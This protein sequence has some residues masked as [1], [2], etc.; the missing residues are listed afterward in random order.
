MNR[1]IA[2]L[3][4]FALALAALLPGGVWQADS[5]I[6]ASS[7]GKITDVAGTA[8]IR[9]LGSVGARQARRWMN[10]FENDVI[11]TG[12]NGK[13]RVLLNDSSVITLTS[14]SKLR[15]SEQVYNP[16]R[17]E[18]RS[19][20]NLF[21]GKVRAVVS[22]YVNAARSKF[23]IHT[24]TAVAGVRGSICVTGF[25]PNTGITE[26]GFETG[27][28]YL[29][30]PE[31]GESM[32]LGAN[33]FGSFNPQGGGMQL[34]NFTQS[35]QN[36]VE[37]EFEVDSPPTGS[38]DLPTDSFEESSEH[39]ETPPE[40]GD[41]GVTDAGGTEGGDTE[42]ASGDDSGG[43]QGDSGETGD[44]GDGGDT[45]G[46]ELADAGDSGGGDGASDVPPDSLTENTG[47]LPGDFQPPPAFSRVKVIITLP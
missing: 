7:A 31:T 16:D 44:S 2:T 37:Q 34:T 26:H 41:G 23:E 3:S 6:A 15:V 1:R 40:V 47:T 20:F 29:T 42:I 28:G 4:V 22:K 13:V 35:M 38:D 14:D 39:V 43:D 27:S 46:G 33:Q 10:I 11:E 21:R 19:L 18:R 30:N 12:A 32:D 25:D 45:G 36:E 17:G 9:R 24:P 8:E 5:V